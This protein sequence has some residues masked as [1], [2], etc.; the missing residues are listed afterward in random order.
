MAGSKRGASKGK[1]NESKAAI[2]AGDGWKPSKCSEADIE[3]LVDEGLLQSK[4]IIQ[5]HAATGD[6]R[7][8][9]GT[10]ELVLFQYFVERGLALPT[11]DFFHGLL[12]YYRIQLHHRNPNSILHIAI[13][14]QFCE[15]FLGIEPHFDLFC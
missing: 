7:P 2:T 4:A 3:A 13:F 11:Y 1:G 6:R 12:F 10:D 8:Y 9:E 15:V 5:W 14:V